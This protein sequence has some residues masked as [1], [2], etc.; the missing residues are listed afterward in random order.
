MSWHF[1]SDYESWLFGSGSVY[2]FPSSKENREFEHFIPFFES[3]PIYTSREYSSN[4]LEQFKR[5][6]GK[7]FKTTTER[8]SARPWW[9]PINDK[10]RDRALHSKA[11]S[12]QLASEL[13]E[14]HG[15]LVTASCFS[16]KEGHLYKALGELSGRGNF[17]WP[18]DQTKIQKALDRGESLI[19]E[20]LRDRFFDFSSLVLE[21]GKIVY[22][23]NLV[24]SFFH[25]KGTRLGEFDWSLIPFKGYQSKI[26][27]VADHYLCLGA[28]APFSIDSYLYREE[29]ETKLCLISEV[30]PRKTMG[31]VA[32][33]FSEIFNCARGDFLLGNRSSYTK[34]LKENPSAIELSPKDNH[35]KALFILR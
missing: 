20:P 3:S 4:Y 12:N 35:L 22:Y 1:N 17:L 25:Y 23:Q 2:G 10:D 18:K 13:G 30:N 8:K 29:G 24:D 16:P 32:L 9:C 31:Y 21:S 34:L 11:T 28:K 27:K 15:K 5:L 6:A 19:E 7:E 26:E 33:K 14:A